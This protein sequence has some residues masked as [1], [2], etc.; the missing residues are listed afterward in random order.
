MVNSKFAQILWCGG[1]RESYWATRIMEWL[2]AKSRS[3]SNLPAFFLLNGSTIVYRS[4][5][6]SQAA[7]WDSSVQSVLKLIW[8][9]ALFRISCMIFRCYPEIHFNT[10]FWNLYTRK[11]FLDTKKISFSKA[12]FWP[13]QPGSKRRNKR[14]LMINLN[15]LPYFAK[16]Q[17]TSVYFYES[18][19][20]VKIIKL[21]NL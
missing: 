10:H 8:G 15:F 9:G 21:I 11:K 6:D 7:G 1:A 20:N 16:K 12:D 3:V 17:M 4:Y 2:L 5:V 19:G 18:F 14:S 13:R